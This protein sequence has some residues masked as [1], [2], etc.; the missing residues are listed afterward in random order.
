MALAIRRGETEFIC[1]FLEK[2]NLVLK[3]SWAMGFQMFLVARLGA[4]CPGLDGD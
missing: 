1:G 4:A 2:A 3:K